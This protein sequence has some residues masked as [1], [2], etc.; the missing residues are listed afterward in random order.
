MLFKREEYSAT[1]T[2]NIASISVEKK[3]SV[4]SYR[5]IKINFLEA[6][7]KYGAVNV[8]QDMNILLI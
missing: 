5:I 8:P 1:L 2:A 4:S 3:A 6:S 7:G